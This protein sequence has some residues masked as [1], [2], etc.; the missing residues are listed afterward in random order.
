MNDDD[1]FISGLRFGD[2]HAWVSNGSMMMPLGEVTNVQVQWTSSGTTP[3]EHYFSMDTQRCSLCGVAKEDD[4]RQ[5]QADAIRDA[6]AL[7]QARRLLADQPPSDELLEAGRAA[8]RA[9][10]FELEV[11]RRLDAGGQA[12]WWAILV[13]PRGPLEQCVEYPG[14]DGWRGAFTRLRLE[15]PAVS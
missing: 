14:D 4:V 2:A 6:T 1:E 5:R 11:E 9:E 13:T 7:S 12:Y 8:A 15:L 3:C 10:G